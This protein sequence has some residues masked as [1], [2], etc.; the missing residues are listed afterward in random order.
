MKSGFS[1]L[2]LL[3]ISILFFI[4]CGQSENC[5]LRGLNLNGDVKSVEIITTT[6]I[7][8]TEWLYANR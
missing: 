1:T 3:G 4:G 7:P 8:I 6:P 5:D 2:Y